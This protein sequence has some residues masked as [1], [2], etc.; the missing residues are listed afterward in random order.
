MDIGRF[1]GE[2]DDLDKAIAIGERWGFGNVIDVL[3][4]AWS[5]RLQDTGLP[6]DA[7][8]AGAHHVCAWCRV[9]FRTGKKTKK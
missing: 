7:A 9:D 6:K 4:T 8:D 2:Q 3:K 1:A 5:E